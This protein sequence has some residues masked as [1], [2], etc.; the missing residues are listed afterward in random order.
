MLNHVAG[1]LLTGAYIGIAGLLF[2]RRAR[3]GRS[4]LQAAGQLALSN[5]LG[6]SLVCS[7]VF[8]GYGL[9]LYGRWGPARVVVFGVALWARAAGPERGVPAGLRLWSGRVV[10]ALGDLSAAARSCAAGAVAAHT[11]VVDQTHP[12]KGWYTA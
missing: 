3:S 4:P 8:S 1:G 6:Q 12:D 5:Y 9:G 11:L 10:A 7:L 2:A